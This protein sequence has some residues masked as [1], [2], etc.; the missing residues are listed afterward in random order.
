MQLRCSRSVKLGNYL[1]VQRKECAV[2]DE[3][4][5]GKNENVRVDESIT[6]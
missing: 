5:Y 2:D 3:A 1:R 4:V 6:W